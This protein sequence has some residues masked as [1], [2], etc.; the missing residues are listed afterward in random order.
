MEVWTRIRRI[1]SVCIKDIVGGMRNV[2]VGGTGN[3]TCLGIEWGTNEPLRTPRVFFS[4]D[5]ANIFKK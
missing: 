3:L 5:A 4:S 1:Y 2:A